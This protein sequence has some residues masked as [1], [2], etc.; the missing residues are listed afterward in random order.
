MNRRIVLVKRWYLNFDFRG[1]ILRK[2]LVW[3][4]LPKLPLACWGSD[5]LSKIDSL[6]GIPLAADECTTKQLRVNFARMLIEV[7]A[8][9][10]IPNVVPVVMIDGRLI[11]QKLEFERL[12]YYCL[13]CEKV[14]HISEKG[15][16]T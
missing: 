13:K 15:K 1:E 5:S 2:L 7:D 10:T 16:T 11:Q 8:T 14:G 4:R 3:F 9:K 6:V 12:P